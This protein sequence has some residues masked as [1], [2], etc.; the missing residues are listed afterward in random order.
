MAKKLG[1]NA[2][3][4][5]KAAPKEA[6]VARGKRAVPSEKR[7]LPVKRA[8][9]SD[10]RS[11]VAKRPRTTNPVPSKRLH[12]FVCGS[13][14]CG[15][16]GLGPKEHN[17]EKPT[18][19]KRPRLNHLLNPDTVGVI[20]VAV[21]GMH[22]A[23]LT[24]DSRILTWGVNDDGALGRDT[25]AKD[26]DEY[27]LSP[28]ESTPIAIPEQSFPKNPAHF[29]QVV[30]TDSATFALTSDGLVYGWGTF[31][32]SLYLYFLMNGVLTLLRGPKETSAFRKKI[33]CEI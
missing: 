7:A 28:Q 14:E 22:C 20:Q 4:A 19:A 5:K 25:T 31:N 8:A 12:V 24:H 9:P 33:Y 23:A 30:A 2:G 3:P 6:K 1:D 18:C 15:E 17:G 11:R 16:L 32:V 10:S 26:D 27:D 13:G 21:G 29:S